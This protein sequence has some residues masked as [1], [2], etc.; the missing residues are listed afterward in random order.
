MDR[1]SPL[2]NHS[3]RQLAVGAWSLLVI[4]LG[5]DLSRLPSWLSPGIVLLV[6]IIS[7]CSV[8]LIQES[9]FSKSSLSRGSSWA[10]ATIALLIPFAW[11]MLLSDWRSPFLGFALVLTALGPVGTVLLLSSQAKF[12]PIDQPI[13]PQA[14]CG[15][16]PSPV[17]ADES[18]PGSTE[19][20][21]EVEE[22]VVEKSVST[23]RLA[24]FATEPAKKTDSFSESPA[25][26][27][28][29]WLTRSH[30]AEGEIIEG[31]FRVDFQAGQRDSTIHV[32]F[33]PPFSQTPKIS[34]RDLDEANLEIQVAASFPFGARLTVRRSGQTKS[35]ENQNAIRSCRIGFV[36]VAVS[37]KK[38]A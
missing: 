32:S 5:L 10:R 20:L 17:Q 33:C 18:I 34:T 9:G 27:V 29:Q 3:R 13:A 21:D 35:S 28:T 36:A 25:S 4:C 2:M 31:G 11:S 24:E 12:R 23:V 7:S 30:T 1:V 37:L 26:D 22:E 8:L 38:A 19:K 14:D 6:S 15:R 16:C